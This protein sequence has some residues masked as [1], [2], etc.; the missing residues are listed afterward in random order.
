M[1]HYIDP[2]CEW[3]YTKTGIEKQLL[4]EKHLNLK[5]NHKEYFYIRYS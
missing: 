2:T 5:L 3:W 1:K 4:V